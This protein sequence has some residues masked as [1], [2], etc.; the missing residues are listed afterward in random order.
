MPDNSPALPELAALANDNSMLTRRFG[1][2]VIH[3]YAGSRLNRYSFLRPDSTFLKPAASS[4]STQYI[5][6]H[7]LNPL[8]VD[9]GNF[10]YLSFEDVKPLIGSEP[11]HLS[12]AETIAEYDSTVTRPLM[13]F[14]GMLDSS[15]AVELPSSQH[16]QI[17]GQPF[18]AV[19]VT[20]RG[21]YKE[22]A[23]TFLKKMEDKG[24]VIQKDPRAMSLHADAGECSP[25][26]PFSGG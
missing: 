21:T 3:Y 22:A 17:K 5:A 18:F 8:T 9:K 2:E 25:D 11:F 15:E 16:G 24:L 20:P 4:P 7:E 6:L 13:V 10:A 14:L 1:K 19:D 23:S 26:P 12:E